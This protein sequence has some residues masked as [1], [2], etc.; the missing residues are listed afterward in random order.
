[1][2]PAERAEVQKQIEELRATRKDLDRQMSN[3]DQRIE[4]LES[5][6]TGEAPATQPVPA[7]AA[8]TVAS[9]TAP[10]QPP[11]ATA[12]D[13]SSQVGKLVLGKG[14][15]LAASELGE[16]DWSAF[17]YARYLNQLSLNDSYTDSFGR[18][19]AV[20]NREDV[21]FQKVALNF[22]GWLLD[23]RFTYLFYVWTQN[24]AQGDPAQVV[25]GG[26][27]NWKFDDA[28]TLSA[29][30][31]AL[32]T[33]RTTMYTFPNW[34]RNDNRTVA[35]EFFRGSYHTGHLGVGKDC[36]RPR[37]PRDGGQQPQRAG[38]QCQRARQQVQ[39]R[40]RRAV[41]DANHRRVRAHQRLWRL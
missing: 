14:F 7:A 30:I 29:G 15:V 16:L 31:G 13:A 17:T 22:K 4:Q 6:L 28:L 37:I 32:P 11:V 5:R 12:G 3:F 34:L 2:T 20:K 18:T 35:D 36:A 1:M 25:V 23:Q 41:V 21:Q 19:F 38:H 27:L 24:V 33:T 10:G 26:N 8:P 40:I 9:V 39:H